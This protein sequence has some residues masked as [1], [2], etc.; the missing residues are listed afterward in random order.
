M[1]RHLRVGS[2]LFFYES[3]SRKEIV[4]EARIIEVRLGTDA[5]VLARYSDRLFL[6]STEFEEYVGNRKG[7][8]LLILVVENPKR[9]KTPMK[10]AKPITMSGQY[11]TLEAYRALQ[12]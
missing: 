8:Q 12:A 1:P 7:K 3:Q 6:T 2:R 9:Y 11:M 5:E 10:T 4:G